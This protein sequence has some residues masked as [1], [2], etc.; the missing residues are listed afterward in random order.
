MLA[1]LKPAI[2]LSRA[3]SQVCASLRGIRREQGVSSRRWQDKSR[4][5][6]AVGFVSRAGN[7]REFT[8]IAS[9]QCTFANL[10]ICARCSAFDTLWRAR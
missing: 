3:L 1:V 2:A 9:I 5:V 7:S 6:R 10:I 8:H 4:K